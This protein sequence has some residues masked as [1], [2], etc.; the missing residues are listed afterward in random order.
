MKSFWSPRKGKH[1]NKTFNNIKVTLLC[2]FVTILV[3]RGTIGMGGLR[4]PFSDLPID[5]HQDFS[6]SF[7][8][9]NRVLSVLPESID[10]N[11]DEEDDDNDANNV[12]SYNFLNYTLGPKISDWDVQLG[13]W[14]AQNVSSWHPQILL[15]TGSSS[16]PCEQPVGDHYLLKSIK[17]KMDYARLHGLEI[18]YNMAELDDQLVGFWSKLPL[19]RRLMLA[20]PEIEWLWWMDSDAMFTDMAFELPIEK[21]K[22]HNLVLHGWE[23]DV[24]Q[25][26]AWVG[27]NTGSFVIRNCQWSLDLFDAWAPMGPKGKVRQEMG[28]VFSE[29]LDGRPPFEAD[30]QSALVYLLIT[31]RELWAS[32]VFLENAYYLHGYWVNIVDKYEDLML[33][34]H[35]G[36]GDDRWP[37]VTHFVGCKPCGSQGDYSKDRCLKEMERAFNFGDNQ[38]L[39]TYGFAHKSLETSKV[40]KTKNDTTQP[41][42][43]VGNIQNE[44]NP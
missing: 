13:T 29:L 8:E 19:L 14:R 32:K 4:M 43:L 21:Y 26:R 24:Y 25:K 10:K 12:T 31:Q 23:E 30:D 40:K 35:N 36:Y 6:A 17:N 28:S 33:V 39:Q 34:S 20:H 11:D 3:L 42:V 15:V 5:L 37:F 38:I 2:G 16:T 22:N 27:L 1:V 9:A 18:F 41:L 7:R 44:L